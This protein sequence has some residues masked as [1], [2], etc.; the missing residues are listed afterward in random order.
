MKKILLIVPL[1][2]VLFFSFIKPSHAGIIDTVEGWNNTIKFV[3]DMVNAPG[4]NMSQLVNK[5]TYGSLETAFTAVC[6]ECSTSEDRIKSDSTLP[7]YMKIGL[8]GMVDNQVMAMFKE[9]P[10]I[11][12][13]AHLANEWVPGYEATNSVYASGYE[14]LFNAGISNLWSST[15]N[16]AY[17]G[18]VIIMIAI[19]FM[20]MFRNKIGGQAL[21][22]I[23]NSIPKVV[24]SLVL[25]TFSFA[26]IGVIIDFGGVL[27]KVIADLIYGDSTAGIPIY[28][29]I[30][31]F[32]GFLGQNIDPASWGTPAGGLGIAAIITGLLVLLA[33]PGTSGATITAGIVLLVIG[34]IIAGIIIW[35]AIKLWIVLIKAYLSLLINLIVS[36]ISIL[37]GALPGNE[38]ST[39]NIFLSALRNVLVFPLAF[40]IVNLPYFVEDKGFSL[41]FPESLATEGVGGVGMGL[42]IQIAKIVAIYAAASAP[43]ILLGIIP[44]TESKSSA[45]AAAAIKSGLSGVPLIGGMFK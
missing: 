25:V 37:L 32:M 4:E 36:P 27:M 41:V 20:I 43:A 13:I 3:T 42:F 45:D 40:A 35:G 6:V 23:G 34:L 28:N 39:S 31:L 26:I 11:D 21:V 5:F 2:F 10:R 1:V 18:F 29:P 33:N 30:E 7:E 9:Q 19:G 12:V 14:D 22:T 15:R 16:I 44:S 17:V 8:A 24:V 38:S